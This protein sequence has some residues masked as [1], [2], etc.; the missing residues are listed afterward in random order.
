MIC[1]CVRLALILTFLW[2]SVAFHSLAE[3]YSN[4]G[5]FMELGM[6]A[7]PLAMGNAFVG[8]ADDGHALFYNP[9]GLMDVKDIHVLSSCETRLH[10]FSYGHLTAILP[11]FGLSLHLFDFGEVAEVDEFGNRVGTF[12]YQDA[13]AVVGA[14]LAGGDVP[15]LGWWS[16][17]ASAKLIRMGS[18]SSLNSGRG[19]DVDLGF[20]LTGDRRGLRRFFITGYRFGVFFENLL[21]TG[22]SWVG[23]HHE[24]WNR[25]MTIGSS[26]EFV[27][28]LTVVADSAVGKGIRFGLEWT[29]LPPFSFRTGLRYEEVLMYSFGFGIRT[30]QF[31][32]DYALVANPYLTPQHRLTLSVSLSHL[33][34]K[35]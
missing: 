3:S 15:G 2:S 26:L 9:A 28:Q 33:N 13:A 21:G 11:G 32:I 7:R 35:R 24:M 4:V 16:V 10:T 30:G 27:G 8:L 29:P 14:G 6:G 17:G 5:S 12:S 23:G 19:L 34:P 22:V 1:R 20:L 18:S 25:V 31:T